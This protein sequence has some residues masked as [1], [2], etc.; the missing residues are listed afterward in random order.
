[1][2]NTV[3]DEIIGVIHEYDASYNTDPAPG[4]TAQQ[5]IARIVRYVARDLAVKGW[6]SLSTAAQDWHDGAADDLRA[7]KA[8]IPEPPG[9]PDKPTEETRRRRSA[10]PDDPLQSERRQRRPLGGDDDK[11]KE[12]SI[13]DIVRSTILAHAKDHPVDRAPNEQPQDHLIRTM[14][15]LSRTLPE[16]DFDKMPEAARDYYFVQAELAEKS[17][18]FTFPPGYPEG[19]AQSSNGRAAETTP[20]PRRNATAAE[21]EE[22]ATDRVINYTLK[23]HTMDLAKLKDS[24]GKSDSGVSDLKESTRAV[25]AATAWKVIARAKAANLWRA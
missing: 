1:M 11:P 21:G 16:S 4:E 9:Y 13:W 8:T 3:Y 12:P 22:N 5:H 6:D 17:K 23:N 14:R 18:P 10:I 19:P 25:V 24:M 15:Y 20:T 2:A 7:G